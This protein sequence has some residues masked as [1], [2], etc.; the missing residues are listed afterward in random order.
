MALTE[1]TIADVLNAGGY[2]SHM[3]G[4]SEECCDANV[5]DWFLLACL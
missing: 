1:R 4:V 5:S 2:E 3:I